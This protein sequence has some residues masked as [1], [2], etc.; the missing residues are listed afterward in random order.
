MNCTFTS[1]W[2][3]WPRLNVYGSYLIDVKVHQTEH[4]QTIKSSEWNVYIYIFI[5]TRYSNWMWLWYVQFQ[6]QASMHWTGSFFLLEDRVPFSLRD[7]DRWL[8]DFHHWLELGSHIADQFEINLKAMGFYFRYHSASRSAPFASQLN[9]SFSDL[10]CLR[11]VW[12][13][14]ILSRSAC[15]SVSSWWVCASS[16]RGGCRWTKINK[17]GFP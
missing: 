7:L 11:T 10:S 17:A 16:V 15:K 13:L 4:L 14:S 1:C 6:F 2:I 12:M 3:I 8:I 5:Y 9:P